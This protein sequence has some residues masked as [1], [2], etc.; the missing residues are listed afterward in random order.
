MNEDKC[1]RSECSSGCGDSSCTLCFYV[2]FTKGMAGI[3]N[4]HHDS[5]I[6]LFLGRGI[7]SL[8]GF[9]KSLGAVMEEN[10]IKGS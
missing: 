4:K 10:F 3:L 2:G 6:G 5:G 8:P 1:M 7:R 9:R